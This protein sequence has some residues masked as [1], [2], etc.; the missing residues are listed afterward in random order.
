MRQILDYVSKGETTI[1]HE[2]LHSFLK[3]AQKLKIT[4]IDET[5]FEFV[6]LRKHFDKHIKESGIAIKC[7]KCP[8]ICRNSVKNNLKRRK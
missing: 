7:E 8:K 5:N 1:N 4:G 3:A 2:N 6:L